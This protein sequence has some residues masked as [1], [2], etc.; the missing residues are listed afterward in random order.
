MGDRQLGPM[1]SE[2]IRT[3]DQAG[4]SHENHTK[5]NKGM[6]SMTGGPGVS[7]GDPLSNGCFPTN[8]GDLNWPSALLSYL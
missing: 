8:G 4:I 7:R 2:L 6:V 1:F 5:K 3:W